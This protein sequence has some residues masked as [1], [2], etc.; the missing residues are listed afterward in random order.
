[1][2]ACYMS[3]TRATTMSNAYNALSLKDAFCFLDRSL[4]KFPAIAAHCPFVAH[5]RRYRNAFYSYFIIITVPDGGGGGTASKYHVL[6]KIP[7]SKIPLHL[8]ALVLT[9]MLLEL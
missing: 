1:M 5:L 4:P 2:F 8:V 7:P 3:D 6:S 9:G